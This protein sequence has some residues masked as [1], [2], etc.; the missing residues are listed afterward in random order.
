MT[1]SDTN[2]MSK[3]LEK[4]K[5]LGLGNVSQNIVSPNRDA[6]A[7]STAYAYVEAA[8]KAAVLK[9]MADTNINMAGKCTVLPN[10]KLKCSNGTELTLDIEGD[11]PTSGELTFD[12]YGS[13]VTAYGLEIGEYSVKYENNKAKAILIIG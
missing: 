11:A 7:E 3:A 4:V 8:E 2:K 5:D 9:I 13:V 1:P 10:S 12:K 6:V